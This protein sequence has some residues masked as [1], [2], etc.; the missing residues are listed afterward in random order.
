MATPLHHP[1]RVLAALSILAAG[2][3]AEPTALDLAIEETGL[4]GAL[5]PTPEE[6][7]TDRFDSGGPRARDGS[8]TEVWAV[9]R[10]WT[11]VEAEAGVAWEEGSELT[12][13]QKYDRWV[14]SFVRIPRGSYGET[15]ELTTPYGRTLPAPALECAEVA[16]MLRATFASWYGLPFFVQGWDSESRRTMYAGHFGFVDSAGHNVARFPSFRT[17]YA[18]HTATWRPGQPWPSDTTLRGRRLG[19]DDGNAFL[20]GAGAGAY[21]DE[22]FL[23]KRVGHFLR[24]LLVFFGSINLADDANTFDVVPEAVAP[25]DTLLE[26]WQR[27]GIGHTIPVMRVAAPAPDRL[28]VEIAT[29]SMPRRQPVWEGAASARR[30]F[31]MDQTGGL[32]EDRDGNPYWKLGGG[33]KR[34]RTA[35]RA[36]GRWRNLVAAVDREVYVSA[37]DEQGISSRPARFGELLA[38]VPPEEKRDVL[39]GQIEAAR[40]HLRQYPASCSARTRREVAFG[41][42]YELMEQHFATDRAT[43]DATYRL[44]EDA[45]LGELEYEASRTCC[46]NSSTADMFAAIL[47]YAEREQAEAEAAG[48]CV[49]P[50]VFRAEEDGYA[51]W[52]AHAAELGLGWNPWREDESCPQRDVASDTVTGRAGTPWCSRGEA[53]EPPAPPAEA[54]DPDPAD[55]SLAAAG[56]LSGE[57]AGRICDGDEDWYRVDG[58]A[59]V[60]IAFRHADGDLDLE[61]VDAAGAVIDSSTTIGDSETVQGTGSFFVRV[62]GYAGAT[63]AYTITAE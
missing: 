9:T 62:Y 18:D 48:T 1:A 40:N 45:A 25:G 38:D 16:Y 37:D 41:E 49:Q 30:Y 46:W 51:R 50:T 56:A 6:Q 10:A 17:R 5:E 42:L 34:W 27:R 14:A 11:D 60:R 39:L 63:G 33:L 12:W 20:E 54:C 15:F 2:C 35:T 58:D 26:R 61:A 23:N 55:D 8:A 7:K 28:A 21:F 59:T 13:E 22:I 31:T 32:G 52:A 44:L 4:A 3:A 29:G 19:N 47:S 43:V 36:D 57:A 24:L 53:P